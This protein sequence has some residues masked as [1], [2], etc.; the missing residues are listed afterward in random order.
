MGYD[1]YSSAEVPL[2][3][4]VGT[5]T[6]SRVV[7]SVRK[8][9]PGVTLYWTV[10]GNGWSHRVWKTL[11]LSPAALARTKRELA[12]LGVHALED[13]DRDPPVP[14]G[15]MC[16]LV[17]DEV[18]HSEGGVERSVVSWEILPISDTAL[19]AEEACDE[20]G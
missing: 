14:P 16:R 3:T 18:T 11:W 17:V 15:A 5:L 12:Q 19:V 2:G 1:T 4:Y 9:T 10:R 20:R 7:Q 13:L 6:G 8:R